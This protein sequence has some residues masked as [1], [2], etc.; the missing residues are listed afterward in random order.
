MLGCRL[1]VADGHM[2][3]LLLSATH[4]A[5]RVAANRLR[6]LGRPGQLGGVRAWRTGE[7]LNSE[8]AACAAPWSV[9]AG[10]GRQR[11]SL[12]RH[13]A[14]RDGDDDDDGDDGLRGRAVGAGP[15]ARLVLAMVVSLVSSP[16]R[17]D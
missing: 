8:C 7:G 4:Y 13:Q 14:G 15:I 12:C 3:S 11:P 2:T 6:V 1:A 17:H 10:R 16:S 5:A 9:A